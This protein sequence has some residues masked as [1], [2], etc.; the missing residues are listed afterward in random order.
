MRNYQQIENKNLLPK[1]RKLKASYFRKKIKE[2]LNEC[3]SI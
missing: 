1:N 3:F 2:L